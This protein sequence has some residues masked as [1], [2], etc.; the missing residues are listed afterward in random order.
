M[1][2]VPFKRVK[3]LL[4]N[5]KNCPIIVHTRPFIYI[6]GCPRQRVCRLPL[7]LQTTLACFAFDDISWSMSRPLKQ[8]CWTFHTTSHVFSLCPFVFR[9]QCW[10]RCRRNISQYET[11][12][13]FHRRMLF[14]ASI[15]H[16]F[17]DSVIVGSFVEVSKVHATTISGS[18]HWAS[19]FLFPSPWWLLAR[20][21]HRLWGWG[22]YISMN[23]RTIRYYIP[24]CSIVRTF[25]YHRF[26]NLKSIIISTR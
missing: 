16:N 25:H 14:L 26:E 4:R 8:R 19:A 15:E 10:L 9:S 12:L 3:L 17:C 1:F 22:Q 5:N 21:T 18:K 20:L 24:E 2:I 6:K 23:C 13:L 7:I 11:N